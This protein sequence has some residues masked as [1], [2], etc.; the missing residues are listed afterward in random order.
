MQQSMN[1]NE[2]NAI[3]KKLQDFTTD[4]NEKGITRLAYSAPDQEAHR[5]MIDQAQALGLQ[6]RQDD[7]GNVFIRLPGS[8]PDLPAVGTGSH[9]D[10]VPLGG[11]YDGAVGVL[12]GLYALA[13][14]KPGQLKRSLE[15]VIFRAEESSRF[16]FA[17]MASKVMTGVADLAKWEKNADNS[18]KTFQ[19]VLKECGYKPENLAACCLPENYFSAFMEVH[20]EQGKVLEQ[21]KKRLGLVTGIA[22]PNRFRID[23]SGHAD[24]SGATPMNQRSDALVAS[25]AIITDLSAAACCE[26]LYG[27]VGTVGKLDVSPNA[28]NVIPGDVRFYVDIRGVDESSIARVAKRLMA[29]IDKVGVDHSVKID[30]LELSK[31]KPVLLNDDICQLTEQVCQD[32]QLSA[33]RMI[34]GAG[35]DAMYMAKFFPTSMI[36]IPSKDGIS[37]HPDEFSEFDDVLLAAS[38]LTEC[39]QKLADR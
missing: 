1:A 3:F 4:K 21:Q 8:Q 25:A 33:M 18:G 38:V 15:L 36:F 27:T 9:I 30:V 35:H 13:Q 16:G 23:V 20:I 14:F 11:A 24:H 22:A 39:M 12:A 5:F 29:S 17:C 26:S 31:D 19:Q 32:K 2:L 7:M 34:S 37:H 6:V 10:T 28:M